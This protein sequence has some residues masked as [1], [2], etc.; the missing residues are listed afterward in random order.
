MKEESLNKFINSPYCLL[1]TAVVAVPLSYFFSVLGLGSP[2]VAE[3][4]CPFK[5]N[6][7]G[8]WLLNA[9]MML[10]VAVMMRVLDKKFAF[11]REYTVVYVTYFVSAVLTNP[12]YAAGLPVAAASVFVLMLCVLVLFTGYQQKGRR[13]FVFLISFI[14]SLCSL[15]DYVFVLYLP[16]FVIGFIQMKMF[17]FK[18]FLAMLLGVFTP[19]WIVWGAGFAGI[20]ELQLPELVISKELFL[21]ELQLPELYRILLALVVGTVLGVINL[22]KLIS[23]RLQ[24]RSYNG[25]ITVLALFTTLL[26]II[27]IRNTGIYLMMLNVCVAY[28]AAHFFTIYKLQRRYVLFFILIAANFACCVPE[29]IDWFRL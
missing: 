5:F 22:F 15:F 23:Y 8:H 11:V 18:G 25:F 12:D 6:A 13:Q 9:V 28:Q 20:G 2:V 29:I 4:V 10:A 3:G 16:V 26:I 1:A 17:S 19:Y 27:D 24:L 21:S 14:L 7:G